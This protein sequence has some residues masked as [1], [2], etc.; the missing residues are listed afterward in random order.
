VARVLHLSFA[1]GLAWHRVS[2]AGGEIKLTGHSALEQRLRLQ[3][4]GVTFRG[5]RIDMARHAFQ[6]P[7]GR[8]SSKKSRGRRSRG[9]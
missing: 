4:E 8:G 3:S 6:F 7:P 9:A 2:G 5:R 1:L